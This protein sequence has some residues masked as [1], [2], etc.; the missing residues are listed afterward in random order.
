MNGLDIRH[1][2]QSE[3]AKVMSDWTHEELLHV[4]NKTR[5]EKGGLSL[6]EVSDC[7]TMVFSPEEIA[8]IKNNL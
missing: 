3:A 1:L 7:L 6:M 5:S 2:L 4:L 8:M